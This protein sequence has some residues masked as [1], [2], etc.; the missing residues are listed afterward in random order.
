MIQASY[1]QSCKSSAQ[2]TPRSWSLKDCEGVR[3][4]QALWASFSTAV[5]W[6]V[7]A[8]VTA[9]GVQVGEGGGGATT[10][11]TTRYTNAWT[12]AATAG[13]KCRPNHSDLDQK[14]GAGISCYHFISKNGWS[15][16]VDPRWIH[17]WDFI[18]GAD[19]CI[20]RCQ[21]DCWVGK[22]LKLQSIS[23]FND[24]VRLI[25]LE[26]GCN[27]PPADTRVLHTLEYGERPYRVK[28]APEYCTRLTC[29][30]NS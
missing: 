2:P 14:C 24:V 5:W 22:Q 30:S 8:C 29:T 19:T 1:S 3:S 13:H 20:Q 28:N 15:H 16:G 27:N 26:S 23:T 7:Q 18:K 25:H 12:G 9:A 11:I 10:N 21:F 17:T 4:V 6:A